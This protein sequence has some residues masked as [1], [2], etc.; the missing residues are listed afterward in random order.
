[1]KQARVPISMR[2]S[3][4]HPFPGWLP[5]LATVLVLFLPA[6]ASRAHAQTNSEENGAVNG[7]VPKFI[8]AGGVRTRYYEMGQGEP[9]VLIH[10]GGGNSPNN[11]NI[12]SLNIRSL[13]K[14]FRVIAPDRLG[15]GLTAG[16]YAESGNY[17][18]QANWLYN[19]LKAMH[20]SQVNLVGHSAGGAVVSWFAVEHPDMIKTLVVMSAGPETPSLRGRVSK[21]DVEMKSCPTK[22][23]FA[24]QKCRLAL[25]SYDPQRAFSARWWDAQLYMKNWRDAHYKI[26]NTSPL[27]LGNPNP[28]FMS[29]LHSVWNKLRSGVLGDRPVLIFYGKQDPFDWAANAPNSD[30][31]GAIGW[32]DI[33]GAKDPNVQMIVLNDAGHFLY[34]DQPAEFDADLTDFV[35]YWDA[36]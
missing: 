12:W 31:R 14:H 23:L 7:L 19:F 13:A 10:G 3:N 21:V 2:G 5:A 25:L 17:Q 16:T 33:V 35:D 15:C 26:P 1:M 24:A 18:D 11:A 20:L 36:R 9:L 22:P 30:L 4:P 28:Q 27:N 29:Q 34:R 32:Y 6:A 8:D